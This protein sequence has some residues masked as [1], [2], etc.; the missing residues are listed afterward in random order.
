MYEGFGKNTES[1]PDERLHE[2]MALAQHHGLPTRLLDWTRN[3]FV[4]CYFAAR[5]AI[6]TENTAD[7]E[8]HPSNSLAI[9]ALDLSKIESIPGIRPIKVPGS[10]SVNLAAQDGLFTLIENSG[11]RGAAFSEGVCLESKLPK[12]NTDILNKITLPISFAG[13]L[14]LRIRKFGFSA[15]SLFPGYDGVAAA[16]L[17]TFRAYNWGKED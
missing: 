3:P 7:N 17:D 10:T 9:F 13:E 14:L 12:N 15:H 11:W 5:T 1:W 8:N 16:V 4:A 6:F 2:L